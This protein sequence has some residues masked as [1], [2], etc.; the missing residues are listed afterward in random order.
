MHTSLCVGLCACM[1]VCVHVCGGLC[2]YVCVCVR[3]CCE[4]VF[5]CSNFL[6]DIILSKS[7]Q[8]NCYFADAQQIVQTAN[9]Q[10]PDTLV[11]T[12]WGAVGKCGVPSDCTLLLSCLVAVLLPPPQCSGRAAGDQGGIPTGRGHAPWPSPQHQAA[13]FYPTHPGPV[14]G[15]QQ[16]PQVHCWLSGKRVWW[17][18]SY[19]PGWS[20]KGGGDDGEGEG[21]MGDRHWRRRGTWGGD[22]LWVARVY[23][24]LSG[25]ITARISIKRSL[26]KWEKRGWI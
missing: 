18:W 21:R 23:H 13:T 2:M 26:W 14:P 1:Y 25:N 4:C 9:C 12:I 24:S 19:T 3:A 10:K 17:K 15:L 11:A 5:M 6:S 7:H 22:L 8:C 20:E 16:V